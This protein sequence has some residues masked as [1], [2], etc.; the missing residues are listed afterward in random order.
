[1]PFCQTVSKLSTDMVRLPKPE[2]P[3]EPPG[4]QPPAPWLT[5]GLTVNWPKL[6]R[7]G[8]WSPPLAPAVT[9]S[10]SESVIVAGDDP[11]VTCS[12]KAAPEKPMAARA[13][14]TI[15]ILFPSWLRRTRALKRCHKVR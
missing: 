10:I 6:S 1:M 8:P 14:N 11:L 12:A 13:A 7:L 15:A 4:H 3:L 9:R 2:F 5:A